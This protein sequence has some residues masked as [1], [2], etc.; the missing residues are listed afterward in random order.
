MWYVYKSSKE[1]EI[2]RGR[3]SSRGIIEVSIYFPLEGGTTKNSGWVLVPGP[4][5]SFRSLRERRISSRWDQA[6]QSVEELAVLQ[7]MR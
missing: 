5:C 6:S 3:M 7:Y 1:S 4:N 2:R